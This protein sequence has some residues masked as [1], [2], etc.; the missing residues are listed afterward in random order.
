[1]HKKIVFKTHFNIRFRPNYWMLTNSASEMELITYN[2]DNLISIWKT[3]IEAKWKKLDLDTCIIVRR[4]RLN[5]R[6]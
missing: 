4:L 2:H 5:K 3:M 6:G 1:M